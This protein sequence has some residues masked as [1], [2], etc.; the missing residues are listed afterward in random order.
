LGLLTQ[1]IGTLKLVAMV[2]FIA[3]TVW[4]SGW[5]LRLRQKVEKGLV[6]PAP[7]KAEIQAMTARVAAVR[8]AVSG[9]E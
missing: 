6:L 4:I 2:G 9:V 3:G 1:Y 8:L 5:E 7:S